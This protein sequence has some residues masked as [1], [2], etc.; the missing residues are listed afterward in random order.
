MYAQHLLIGLVEGGLLAGV[1][2]QARLL[3]DN[4]Q[5]P[6]TVAAPHEL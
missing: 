2:V 6:A 4:P 5:I 3:V 1:L